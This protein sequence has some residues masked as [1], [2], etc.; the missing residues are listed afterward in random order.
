MALWLLLGGPTAT[1]GQ[2]RFAYEQAWA[3]SGP[4]CGDSGDDVAVL[5]DGSFIVVGRYGALDLDG[6]GRIDQRS[7]GGHDPIIMKGRPGGDLAWVRAPRSPAESYAPMSVALD[8]Q[9][10]A[11]LAGAFIDSMRF[12]SGERIVSRGAADGLL[13]RY[14]SNGDPLWARAIGGERHDSLAAAASD[15][16][17]NVYV[18]GTVQAGVDLDSD[19]RVEATVTAANGILI[20]SYDLAGALR[21][22]RIAAST[23]DITGAAIAVAADG[24]VL[25]AGHYAGADVDLDRD[26]QVDLPS[27]GATA[28]PFLAHFDPSGRLVRAAAVRGR[29]LNRVGQL[30]V[31]PG[32]DLVASGYT[33]GTADLDSDGTADV[34]AT[35]GASTPYVARLERGGRLRWV[36]AFQQKERIAI[37]AL[38]VSADRLAVG[39]LYQRRL[40]LDLDGRPDANADPDGHSEGLVALLDHG[41]VVQQ[42]LAITGPAQDQVRAAAFSADGRSL[43]V[44]GFL[45]LTA[46]FDGD[47]VPEGAIRCD[48][49]GDLFFGRYRVRP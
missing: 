32:G 33:Q 18:T 21:W 38:A 44:T 12:R 46:D 8:R 13:A 20:A 35:E 34:V 42:V 2:P 39:G 41:G 26:G 15:A 6:D 36:R 37:Q 14:S 31:L 4:C 25:V 27:P 11:F 48:H 7:E 40:D 10:G 24:A 17:G 49:Y 9:G 1:A 30:A 3:L 47:G 16:A 29:G 5:P 19:G 23:G 43:A 45:R 28:A 22:G